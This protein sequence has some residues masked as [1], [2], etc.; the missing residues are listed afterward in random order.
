MCH[1]HIWGK[2]FILVLAIDCYSAM[3]GKASRR[4]RNFTS[5]KGGISSY[6]N[7]DLSPYFIISIT[8]IALF[9]RRINLN[10]RIGCERAK[11]N[12]N[13]S[14]KMSDFYSD[15]MITSLKN[16]CIY[17][18]HEQKSW[19]YQ[20]I[21]LSTTIGNTSTNADRNYFRKR[22]SIHDLLQVLWRIYKEPD[23]RSLRTTW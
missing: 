9:M 2:I 6:G 4:V 10:R 18:K 17:T 23:N 1:R 5:I 3:Q 16:Q 12:L 7:I 11:N 15:T 20:T 13:T 8:N 14:T 22:Y 19:E 21:F